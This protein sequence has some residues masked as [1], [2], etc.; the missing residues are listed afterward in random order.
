MAA[1]LGQIDQR[2]KDEKC[3]EPDICLL[4]TIDQLRWQVLSFFYHLSHLCWHFLP[5]KHSWHKCPILWI[6]EILNTKNQNNVVILWI[7]QSK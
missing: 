4:Q 7:F 2:P 1:D 6:G 5:Y 3:N